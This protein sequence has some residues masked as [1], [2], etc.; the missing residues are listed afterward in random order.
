MPYAD[1]QRSQALQA[2]AR[3]LVTHPELAAAAGPFIRRAAWS[4]L[5]SQRGSTP[6]QRH[7]AANTTS[8]AGPEGG[9][10]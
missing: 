8:P 10:A 7:R 1:Q 4:I 5:V 3:F 9:A 2:K 6:R